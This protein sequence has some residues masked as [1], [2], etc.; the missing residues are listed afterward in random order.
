[1]DCIFCS[2]DR[3]LIAEND[4]AIAILDGF[5]V[6]PGHALIIPRRHAAAI[7]D[8]SPD[9]YSACFELVRVVK[10]ILDESHHADGYNVGVN[11][12]EAAGQTVMHAHIHV[13][14]RYQGDVENPR[15]GVRHVIPGKGF[16]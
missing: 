6:N 8:L 11:S 12:G 5:P 13:I 9:E 14:P 3:P 7:F 10:A 15:G 16:Y 1:M 4:H 2:P